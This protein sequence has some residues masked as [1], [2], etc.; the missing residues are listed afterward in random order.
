[1]VTQFVEYPFLSFLI[2][3]YIDIEKF[4]IIGVLHKSNIKNQI[5]MTRFFYNLCCYTK[6]IYNFAIL[7]KKSL[8]E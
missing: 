3:L 7:P 1:M 4:I 6:S 8:Y 2:V 5:N